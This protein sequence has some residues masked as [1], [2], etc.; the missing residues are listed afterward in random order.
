[1][2]FYKIQTKKYAMIGVFIA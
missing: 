1:M 2:W